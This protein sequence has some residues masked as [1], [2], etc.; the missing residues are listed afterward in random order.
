MPLVLLG[1]VAGHGF[2][3]MGNHKVGSRN[4]TERRTDKI[5]NE[6]AWNRR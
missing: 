3:S 1:G 2:N 4:A 5:S 6:E